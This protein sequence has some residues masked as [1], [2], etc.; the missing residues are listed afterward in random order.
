MANDTEHQGV[1]PVAAA[2][3][4]TQVHATPWD[5]PGEYDANAPFWLPDWKTSVKLLGWRWMI[6]VGL[7]ALLV[8]FAWLVFHGR[9]FLLSFSGIIVKLGIFVVAGFFSM[10]AYIRKSA[11]QF[12]RDP[13]CVHCGYSLEGHNDGEVCPECGRRSNFAVCRE[14]KR[15]PHWFI[16]RYRKRAIT[17][18]GIVQLHAGPN[19]RKASDGTQ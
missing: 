6:V 17:P 8:L 11:T 19:R 2:E 9:Y 3:L 13:F 18:T 7:V 10:W 1:V 12:R 4:P 14:Y 16:Q 5:V 15:D